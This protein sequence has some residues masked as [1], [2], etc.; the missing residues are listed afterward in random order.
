MAAYALLVC[1]VWALAF[2]REGIAGARKGIRWLTEPTQEHQ[3]LPPSPG[4]SKAELLA[5]V[6]RAR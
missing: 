1:S 6:L 4:A 2:Y 3:V 5:W